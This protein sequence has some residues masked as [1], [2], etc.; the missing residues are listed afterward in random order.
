MAKKI[1]MKTEKRDVVAEVT[2]RIVKALEAGVVPWVRP[3][4]S[5]QGAPLGMPRNALT[6]RAY[7]GVNVMLLWGAGYDDPRWLT[8]HQARGK[9]GTVIKGEKGTPVVFWSTVEKENEDGDLEKMWYAKTFTL[10]NVEQCEGLELGG[11]EVVTEEP[12]NEIADDLAEQVG[13]HVMRRGNRACYNRGTDKITMPQRKSFDC[14]AAY[15]ATLL[16]EL[17]HWTGHESR[18]DREFG[19]RFGDDAYAMEELV[20]EL[21]SAF[22]C[23]T[24]GVEGKL[25]HASYIDSW[26]RVLKADKRA[27]FTAAKQA[28]LAMTTLLKTED[29]E[30]AE[31]A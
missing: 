21:G 20:A 6:G 2:D 19:K 16:H 5:G 10:F 15:S 11:V 4:T 22:L 8:F 25:Q 31:A 18:C 27:V 14:P 7:S 28:Q 3:W 13:A 12:S 26:I 1:E 17:V 9:G 23:A 24:L 30:E 29:A